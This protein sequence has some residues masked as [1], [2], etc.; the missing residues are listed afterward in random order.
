MN[1]EATAELEELQEQARGTVQLSQS[2][3]FTMQGHL[4]KKL[5]MLRNRL[6]DTW[7]QKTGEESEVDDEMQILARDIDNSVRYIIPADTPEN[8]QTTPSP[9]PTPTPT[10]TPAATSRWPLA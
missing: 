4:R 9:T 6:A 5:R 3:R 8:G 2:E 10:P 1:T 7:G